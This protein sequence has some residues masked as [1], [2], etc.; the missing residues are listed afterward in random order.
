MSLVRRP[1]SALYFVVVCLFVV[2]MNY[3]VQRAAW[4][5]LPSDMLP[6]NDGDEASVEVPSAP[7]KIQEVIR[8][9]T[10]S[11]NDAPKA[12]RPKEMRRGWDFFHPSWRETP[13]LNLVGSPKFHPDSWSISEASLRHFVRDPMRKLEPEFQVTPDIRERVLFWMRIHT[14]YS[15]YMRVLHDRNNPSIIYGVADFTPLFRE[16]DADG[17]AMNK[18]YRF[19][20]EIL[21][22]LRAKLTEA[23]GLSSTQLLSPWERYELRTILSKAGALGATESASLIGSIRS[24]TGQRDEFIMALTRSEEL[25]PF[26]EATFRSYGLPV[27]LG[28]IPFV[29]SSFNARAYSKVGAT[30]MWQFMPYT[31]RQMIH[32]TNSELWSDPLLQTRAAARMLIIYRSML[33]DWSTTVTAY[34]SGPGRLSRLVRKHHTKSIGK[35]LEVNDPTGL[36][37]AGKNFYGQFMS[38]NLAQAYRR[39]IF[40]LRKRDDDLPLAFD[41]PRAFSRRFRTAH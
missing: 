2:A 31:A 22:E 39:E 41:R 13:D 11:R 12:A 36:G 1:K 7:V 15:S 29:E 21:K 27:A 18:V 28:R 37:F 24:Q 6:Q 9:E 38:A 40:P 32:S 5:P 30:G 17:S 35:L 3:A 20:R 26:I 19:E 16:S 10:Q 4:L 14:Q 34:N 33:P 8:T 25:L 23:A